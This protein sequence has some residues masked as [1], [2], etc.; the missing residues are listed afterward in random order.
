[1][2]PAGL[3]VWF[4]QAV[5]WSKAKAG[6]ADAARKFVRNTKYY[7][8][9]AGW[10]FSL[11]DLLAALLLIYP[12][13]LSRFGLDWGWLLFGTSESSSIGGNH[14]AMLQ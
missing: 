9:I 5:Q 13:L 4:P 14:H 1:M 8:Q 11:T 2:T 3:F 6:N 7:Y 12:S 10:I